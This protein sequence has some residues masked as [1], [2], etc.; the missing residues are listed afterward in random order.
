M[1]RP[2]GSDADITPDKWHC[3]LGEEYG[4][5]THQVFRSGVAMSMAGARKAIDEAHAWG[6]PKGGEK[7][8][9][10]AHRSG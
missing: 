3:A 5:N 8:F 4:A 9:V 10:M 2:R 6:R 7:Q 1:V